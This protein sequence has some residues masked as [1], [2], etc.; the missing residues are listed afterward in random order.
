M[1]ISFHAVLVERA[2]CQHQHWDMRCHSVGL[3]IAAH[4]QPVHYWH[5]DIANNK[6]GH[7]LLC[8][9]IALFAVSGEGDIVFLL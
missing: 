3:D 9:L 4:L 6:V 2:C 8:A 7:Y 5:H 1:Q